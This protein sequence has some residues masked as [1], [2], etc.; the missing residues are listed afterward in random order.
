M[1]GK[2]IVCVNSYRSYSNYLVEVVDVHMYKDTVQSGQYL[3]ADG[4]KVLRERNTCKGRTHVVH[5]I[6]NGVL[7]TLCSLPT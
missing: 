5:M 1:Y 3:L 7:Y 2:I 6:M 4:N